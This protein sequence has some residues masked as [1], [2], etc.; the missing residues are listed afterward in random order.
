LSKAITVFKE[1]K[2]NL[3]LTQYDLDLEGKIIVI[4]QFVAITGY[5]FLLNEWIVFI[6]WHNNPWDKTLKKIELN[7]TL[8]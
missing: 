8:I 2:H 7:W 4:P 5:N 3:T 1:I 6:L